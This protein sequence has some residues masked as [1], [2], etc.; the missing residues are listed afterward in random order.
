MAWTF[1]TRAGHMP[2]CQPLSI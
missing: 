2:M 1:S